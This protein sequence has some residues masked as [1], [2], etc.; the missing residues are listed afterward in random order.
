MSGNAFASLLEEDTNEIIEPMTTPATSTSTSTTTSSSTKTSSRRAG[1]VG[2]KNQGATCYLNSLLQSL[3]MSPEFRR[4]LY[5]LSDSD[6]GMSVNS[7]NTDLTEEEKK[8]ANLVPFELQSL[9]AQLQISEEKSLIT[10]RVTDSF[11]WKDN[12]ALLQQDVSELNRILIT[13]LERCLRK[14][15]AA[16]LIPGLYKGML[17]H[18]TQCS[19][20]SYISVRKEEYY[21]LTLPVQNMS[22]LIMSLDEYVA[23]TQLSGS[24]QYRCSMCHEKVDAERRTRITSVPP[25]MTFCLNRFTYD[26]QRGTRNKINSVFQFPTELDL[27]SY[28]TQGFSD[29]KTDEASFQGPLMY[30]LA[31][32]II[33]G[34]NANSGHYT[35]YIRDFTGEGLWKELAPKSTSGKSTTVNKIINDNVKVTLNQGTKSE[36]EFDTNVPWNWDDPKANPEV[37]TKLRELLLPPHNSSYSMD[38]FGTHLSNQLSKSWK[39]SYKKQY[40]PFET[41]LRGHNEIFLLQDRSLSLQPSAITRPASEPEP[42]TE[43]IIPPTEALSELAIE[44][45]DIDMT[46]EEH[47]STDT[48][49]EVEYRHKN[50][51]AGLTNSTEEVKIKENEAKTIF[52]EDLA[53]PVPGEGWFYFNDGKVT[54]I[55]ESLLS[56]QFGS[57]QTSKKSTRTESAYMLMYRRRPTAQEASISNAPP[58][59]PDHFLGI[60]KQQEA[61]RAEKKRLTDIEADSVHSQLLHLYPSV[62]STLEKETSSYD[63]RRLFSLKLRKSS[64]IAALHAEVR[65]HYSTSEHFS[66]YLLEASKGTYILINLN[67]LQNSEIAAKTLGAVGL[68]RKSEILVVCCDVSDQAAAAAECEAWAQREVILL[69]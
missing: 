69:M 63:I 68:S 7:F 17:S 1:F 67:N 18:E 14:T 25:I 13:A 27:R 9:F 49:K 58:Q 51:E 28:E 42:E 35:A 60:L 20:C 45:V 2:L 50:V 52:E 3:Y 32:V 66:L 31:S 64:T 8:H 61:E 22:S 43:A 19:L 29:E 21:D 55:H 36:P 30:D 57:S 37:L 15:H 62:T 41:F 39:K 16:N 33:H 54:A 34:G 5:S 12:E 56:S 40:G 47:S 53:R 24:N 44:S 6:L 65:A 23:P 46:Q 48:K 38:E 11:G 59:L 26:W 10:K 4:G